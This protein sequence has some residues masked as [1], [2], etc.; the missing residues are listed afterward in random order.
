MT[1]PDL[2]LAAQRP[3]AAQREKLPLVPLQALIKRRPSLDLSP[4]LQPVLARNSASHTR[5]NGSVEPGTAARAQLGS[6]PA[7]PLGAGHRHPHSASLCV[8]A[9]TKQRD[10][11]APQTVKQAQDHCC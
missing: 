9:C 3:Y 11:G 6:D 10:R 4:S 8:S 5:T 2:R 1:Q 7:A